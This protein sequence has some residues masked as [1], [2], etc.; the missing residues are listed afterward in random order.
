MKNYFQKALTFI[1]LLVEQ[2]VFY[3][4]AIVAFLYWVSYGN[5]Y[6]TIAIF[7]LI[8]ILFLVIPSMLKRKK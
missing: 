4:A 6:I 5:I 2:F 1:Y 8:C 3:I 7:I